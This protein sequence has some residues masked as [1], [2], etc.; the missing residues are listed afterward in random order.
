M[1]QGGTITVGANNVSI[2]DGA[3]QKNEKVIVLQPGAYI[4]VTI[5]DEGLGIPR[6]NLE[7][8]FDPYF[9]TKP[10]GNG[11]GLTIVYSII[12]AHKGAIT[13]DSEVGKGTVF[14]FY[15]PVAK[16]HKQS[17]DTAKANPNAP[18]SN[19]G[20]I[21]V[22]DDDSAVRSVLLQL[23]KNYGYDVICTASGNETITAYGAAM[24]QGRPFTVVVMD[25][26]IPGGM[27]G[28]EAVV[29]LLE[30]DP[31]AKV[32]VASGYSNDPI[33]ANY[34]DYGFCGV[35]AKPFNI[36]EFLA[37]VKIAAAMEKE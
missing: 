10:N 22:M 33:M 4:K 8:I 12:K 28:K 20:S 37:V 21:L 9:T 34:R 3:Q 13:V 7:K 31:S 14:S 32:V 27:G 36:D 35:I 6:E 25:L 17:E 1:P 11:L 19:G 29:K 2:G 23:L 15:V 26:T 18:P 16:P 30:I 24:K 5:K